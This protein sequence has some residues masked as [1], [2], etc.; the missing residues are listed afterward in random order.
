MYAGMPL[1]RD[2]FS[3]LLIMPMVLE[4]FEIFP[5]KSN[6]PMNDDIAK[7]FKL[8]YPFQYVVI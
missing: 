3:T 5:G 6:S 4:Y 7:I 8:I 1:F 2:G